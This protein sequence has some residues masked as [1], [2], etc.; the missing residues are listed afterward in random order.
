MNATDINATQVIL[1]STTNIVLFTEDRRTGAV[2]VGEAQ[3]LVD[4]DRNASV[5][6]LREDE[7]I[8]NVM[9]N[10]IRRTWSHI[11]RDNRDFGYAYDTFAV[12]G[13][14]DWT[15]GYGHHDS[16][17][18]ANIRR[19]VLQLLNLRQEDWERIRQGQLA[20]TEQQMDTLFEFDYDR[21]ELAVEDSVGAEWD[22]LPQWVRA[23]MVNGMFRG[24]LGP[25]TRGFIRAGSW[26][27]DNTGDNAVSREYRNHT[28]WT[29][30]GGVGARMRRNERR[31]LIYGLFQRRFRELSQQ[32]Q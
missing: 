11:G 29:D 8:P 20:L 19:Q 7:G 21:K 6:A 31:F 27:P 26:D 17:I 16:F 23:A 14:Q 2:V 10:R 30:R 13:R 4:E 15:I 28:N 9:L 32:N 1:D 25:D 12:R 5:R 24:D 3:G 18:D 22:N